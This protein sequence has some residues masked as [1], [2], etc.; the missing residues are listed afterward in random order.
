MQKFSIIRFALGLSLAAVTSVG[1]AQFNPNPTLKIGDPAPPI[2]VKAWV[3]GVPV[4]QFERGKVYVMDFWATWCGGCVVSF[5][6]ISSIAEKYKDRVRFVSVDSYEDVKPGQD[7]DPTPRV[8]AFLLTPSGRKLTL[9]VAVDGAENK[10]YASWIKPLRRNGFPST[11]IIDQEGKIAWIDV[12]LDHLEWALD[13]VLAKTWDRD[14][15]A[16]IMKERDAIEDKMFESFR[17]QGPR[18]AKVRQEMLAASEAFEK[19]F[20]DRKD[21]VAFIKFMGLMET[22]Q[23]ELPGILLQMAADPRSRYLNLHD[24]GMLTLMRPGLS[25]ATYAAAAKVLERCLQ[26]DHLAV[27]TGGTLWTLHGEIATAYDKAGKPA[28]A[29]AAIA[30]AIAK[31][32]EDKAPEDQ[33]AKLQKLSA[34]FAP[35]TSK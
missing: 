26:N 29:A 9:D 13:G 33:I 28:E 18:Q 3:R 20:P 19:R 12:N 6:H 15:A 16:A 27:N 11:F 31:A 24:A 32:R 8:K 4:T 35:G 25:K 5:P 34:T 17:V 2:T 7:P 10:M 23:D 30:K 21:A 1:Q 22:R 14:K